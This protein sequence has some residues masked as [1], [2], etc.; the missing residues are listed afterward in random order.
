MFSYV[1]IYF[2]DVYKY[3]YLILIFV[4]YKVNFIDEKISLKIIIEGKLI[5]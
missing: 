5:L 1:S 3:F 4:I 2:R